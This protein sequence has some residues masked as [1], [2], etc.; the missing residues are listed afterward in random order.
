MAEFN[1][2]VEMEAV[3]T[4]GV[5]H[6]A[7]LLKANAV[8]ISFQTDSG[9]V[10]AAGPSEPSLSRSEQLPDDGPERF[11]QDAGEPVVADFRDERW[12]GRAGRAAAGFAAGPYLGVPLRSGGQQ[13][14]LSA[15]RGPGAPAFGS[16]GLLLAQLIAPPL[17]AALH[18]AQLFE[19]ARAGN[20][21]MEALLA[22]TEVMWRP[23]P[24]LDVAGV[25]AEQASRLV[26]GTQCLVSMVPPERPNQFRIVAGSGAWAEQQIGKEWAW[27]GTLAGEAMNALEVRETTQL[28]SRSALAATLAEGGIDTG[29]LIPLTTG[30]ELPDG[31]R[32]LGVIGFYRAGAQ[33]FKPEQRDL[34]DEFGKRVSI[35]LHRAEL[36]EAA[37]EANNRLKTGIDV[38][39][40]LAAALD[41]REVIRRMLRRA[42][43]AISADRA[44]LARVEGEDLIV[45]DT[46]DREGRAT[47]I[48]TRFRVLPDSST[49]RAIRSGQPR[50][51]GALPLQHLA[52]SLRAIHADTVHTADI[53]LVIGDQ[54]GAVL[55]LARRSEPSFT[56]S[57]VETLQLIG[58][59]AAVALRNAQLYGMAHELSRNKSD[60][61]NLAAHELRTPLSVIS[62]YISMLEDGSFGPVPT[63]WAKPLSVLSTKATELG[64][65]VE[66]LLIAARLEAGTIPIAKAEF[67]LRETVEEAL[68]RCEPRARL[69]EAELQ[70]SLPDEPVTVHGDSDHVMRILD[71]LINNALTYTSGKPWL[72]VAVKGGPKPEVT[73]SDH[74][75]GI[76]EEDRE[77]IFE[78][79]VRLDHP[80]LARQPGTGL[81]L[82]ISRELALRLGGDLQLLS[83]EGGATFVLRL[84]APAPASGA[85]G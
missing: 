33:P 57:E 62:G 71:N 67:D 26:P 68:A 46:Y 63:H 22:S 65:L 66:D 54:V 73:I 84:P 23:T 17:A 34:M 72:Q 4:L 82:A 35:T 44:S 52:Q 5:K 13:G 61:M 50:V 10:T 59:A 83:G 39:L 40:D 38:T 60:F 16:E 18:V 55:S 1:G 76:A 70:C 77:R 81:G 30:S 27:Q 21:Q 74:G 64:G 80:D 43:E 49:G 53:P 7:A 14:V 15:F 24:F 9:W 29:R 32:A 31:R 78:R 36:L 37:T 79:F 75:I 11:V 28:Q 2:Q 3:L 47:T 19:E 41:H 12:R 6:V 20:L 69:L 58:N 45:E 48:G 56:T 51:G 85:D 42:V 8:L 25:V